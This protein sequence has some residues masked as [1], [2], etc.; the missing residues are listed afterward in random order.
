[1][2]GGNVPLVGDGPAVP[3]H[4]SDE[5]VPVGAAVALGGSN[6]GKESFE[7]ADDA[8]VDVRIVPVDAAEELLGACATDAAV[9]VV[10]VGVG[11]ETFVVEGCG[12]PVVDLVGHEAAERAAGGPADLGLAGH[13]APPVGRLRCP[14]GGP[15]ARRAIAT[16]V[17]TLARF[18]AR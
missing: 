4:E 1:M 9:F 3:V 18:S 14:C 7:D 6:F 13:V 15:C 2:L 11:V 12:D 16:S 10:T 5:G 17:A 8:G